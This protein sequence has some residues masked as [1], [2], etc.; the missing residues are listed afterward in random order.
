MAKVNFKRIEDSST[1]NDIDIE[2]GAFIVTGDGKTYIDFGT[3]RIPTSGTPD[4]QMSD[5]SRNTVENK[6]IKEYVDALDDRLSTFEYNLVTNG[7]AVKTGRKINDKDEYVKRISTSIS[8]STSKSVSTGLTSGV[9]EIVNYR[10]YITNNNGT[11]IKVRDGFIHNGLDNYFMIHVISG[12]DIQVLT[13][14]NTGWIT[15]DDICII[16]VYYI[17]L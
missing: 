14:S 4:S 11:G 15:N 8:T 3:D 16:D 9:H 12:T 7:D 17:T 2:D 10:G 13:G 1:I 6:V 5:V